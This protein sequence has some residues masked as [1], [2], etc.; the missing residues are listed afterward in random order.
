DWDRFFSNLAPATQSALMTLAPEL[1]TAVH[2]V[3]IAGPLG[4]VSAVTDA[5]IVGKIAARLGWP[6]LADG[7]SPLRNHA[8]LVPNLVTTYHA[9]LRN[10]AVA[11][12]LK[13]EVVLCLG[14]WP[15]SK[16]LREWLAASDAPVWLVSERP[17]NRDAL[18]LRTRH[19]GM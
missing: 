14:D 18:H 19:V 12:R 8:A 7:L 16:V 9:V 10:A 15:T 11:E 17:D 5:N 2:G 4:S 1:A 3:I 6:V 13:P